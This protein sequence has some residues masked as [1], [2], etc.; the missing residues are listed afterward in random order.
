VAQV[1]DKIW[2]ADDEPSTRFPVWTRG[3]VGEVFVE[4]V[5]PLNWSVFG[6]HSWEPGW[7]DAYC[8]MGVFGPEE[9]KPAGQCEVTGCFGG[10]VYINM[11][12]TRVMA[13]RIPG[14]TVEAMDKSLFGDYPDIPPHRPDPRDEN[15]ARTAAV[16]AWLQELFTVDPKPVVDA[17]RRRFDAMRASRP[18]FAA[19]SDA[20]LLEYVR[21]LTSQGRHAFR[22]QVLTGY[23]ANVVVSFVAQMCQAAGAPELAA[24]VSAGLGEIESAGHSF[25]LWA[26]SRQ[27]RI[28]PALTAAFDGG[29]NGVLA[30]LRA[31]SD[32]SAH[33]FI[34]QWDAFIRHWDFFGP[35][36][37][38]L[39]SPTYA[40]APEI[41]LR[42]LERARLAPDSAA[43]ALR[44]GSLAAKREAAISAIA[45]RFE[46]NP[47]AQ[48]QFLAAALASAAHL[49][50]RERCKIHCAMVV[51]EARAAV[52]ELGRRMVERGQLARWEDALLVTDDEADAFVASPAGFSD[53]IRERAARLAV[54]QAK[55]PPFVF[56]GEVPPLSTFKDRGHARVDV[57]AAGTQ[58]NGLGVSPGRYTGRAR[59][60]S[61]LD[62]DSELEPGEVIVA[63]ITDASWGPLFLTAGAVVVETGAMISHAAIV[64][65]E[66]GIPAA[67]SVTDATRRIR[68]G[69]TI[70]VDGNAGTVVVH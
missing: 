22:Q 40:M 66:L 33:R 64:A 59:V 21:S 26:L 42:M 62:M 37:W 24:Q 34:E 15:P 28:S 17:D 6:R 36:L 43:P 1:G 57:A 67:V 45:G 44:A 61:S 35:S 27:I 29:V 31:S 8:A 2:V 9:F 23:G 63:P 68:N 51:H 48:G 70:T 53:L 54:L 13:V 7:R 5:S 3:N 41:P 52:H 19:L 39:R 11:S 60:I 47:Q 20:Q 69:A 12:A 18:D 10:Y 14:L 49:T 30:R 58:L 4:V 32:A 55:E 65:R 50:Q 46:G 38:E 25:D 16:G 56:E